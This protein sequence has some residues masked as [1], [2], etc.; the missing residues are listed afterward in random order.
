MQRASSVTPGELA[1][2][3]SWEQRR[4]VDKQDESKR[5]KSLNLPQTEKEAKLA[6]LEENYEILARGALSD[7]PV[8]SADSAN[9]QRQWGVRESDLV[10]ARGR[11]AHML[12]ILVQ[13]EAV[14]KQYSQTE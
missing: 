4:A 10:N 9:G 14:E 13:I 1:R 6:L 11:L 5:E 8:H 2:S 3:G 7:L 12:D